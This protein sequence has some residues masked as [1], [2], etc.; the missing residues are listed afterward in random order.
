MILA[1]KNAEIDEQRRTEVL[2]QIAEIKDYYA[3]KEHC[4]ESLL[5]EA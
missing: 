1:I 3:I 2:K 5:S 4:L